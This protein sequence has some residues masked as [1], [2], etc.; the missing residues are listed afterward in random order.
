MSIWWVLPY[1]I[2]GYTARNVARNLIESRHCHTWKNTTAKP[3][4]LSTSTLG[5]RS[6]GLFFHITV[7]H[8]MLAV[9]VM[10]LCTL[11][12]LLS[13]W[14]LDIF[15]PDLFS[16]MNGIESLLN[17]LHLFSKLPSSR[18]YVVN[19]EWTNQELWLLTPD[20]LGTFLKRESE[21]GVIIWGLK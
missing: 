20:L 15:L 11:K 8:M 17:F 2:W 12:L 21:S 19:R 10:P 1:F 16:K 6:V 4:W 14:V 9:A 18:S 7:T 13:D 3:P 5:A